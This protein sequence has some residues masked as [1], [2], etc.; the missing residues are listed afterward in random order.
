MGEVRVHVPWTFF[1]K[2]L[3]FNAEVIEGN[4]MV[5]R[6]CAAQRPN[7]SQDDGAIRRSKEF[8]LFGHGLAT[9]IPQ[10]RNEVGRTGYVSGDRT[11][12]IMI[13]TEHRD[14][15]GIRYWKLQS[16]SDQ[17][18]GELSWQLKVSFYPPDP[19]MEGHVRRLIEIEGDPGQYFFLACRA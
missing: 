6:A 1:E 17:M 15:R 7:G 14:N 5:V 10:V 18:P 9:I 16:A 2:L 11:G 4:A 8:L 3:P 19:D 12:Y 13:L